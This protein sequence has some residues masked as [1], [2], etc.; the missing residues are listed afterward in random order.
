MSV[1]AHVLQAEQTKRDRLRDPNLEDD[2]P[3]MLFLNKDT[4]MAACRTK[5]VRNL[6]NDIDIDE[7]DRTDLFDA[8]DADGNGY[9]EI[10]ELIEGL[11][12]M[13]G[14]ARKADTVASRLKINCMMKMLSDVH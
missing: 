2:A 12:R 5:E 11:V 13:S 3:V 9:I 14:T 7:S 4:F 8:L 1:L 6:L 10:D